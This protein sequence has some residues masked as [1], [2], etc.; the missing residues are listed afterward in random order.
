MKKI[1][2]KGQSG[3]FIT[4]DQKKQLDRILEPKIQKKD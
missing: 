2:Y 3:Y 1:N 4:Q